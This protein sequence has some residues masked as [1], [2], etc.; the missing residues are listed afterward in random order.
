MIKHIIIW[1]FKDEISPEERIALKKQLSDGFDGLNGKIDGLISIKLVS[2]VLE[3]STGDM[4]LDS[5]FADIDALK[6]YQ[7]NPEHLKVATIVRSVVSS[8]KCIDFEI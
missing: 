4:M 7:K 8:R 5:C 6:S 1:N 3:S 2:D